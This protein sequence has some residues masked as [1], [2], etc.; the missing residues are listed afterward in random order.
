MMDFGKVQQI[1]KMQL[2]H[3][4]ARKEIRALVEALNLPLD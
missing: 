2:S 4:T 3:V 1:G